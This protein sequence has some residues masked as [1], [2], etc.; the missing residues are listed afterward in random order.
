[1]FPIDIFEDLVSPVTAAQSVLHTSCKKRKDML[2]KSMQLVMQVLTSPNAD[3]K[4][5]D[6]A[7]HMVSKNCAFFFKCLYY[8]SIFFYFI[9]VLFYIILF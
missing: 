7:L 5:K 8:R 3:A 2:Q 4:Q 9:F 6:G 1:M